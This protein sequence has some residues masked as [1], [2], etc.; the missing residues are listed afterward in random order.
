[1]N[2]QEAFDL[3]VQKSKD[4]MFPSQNPETKQC[5]YRGPNGRC[6]GVGVL[7]PDNVYRKH[8]DEGNNCSIEDLWAEI[9]DKSWVPEDMTLEDL[10]RLQSIHDN[11]ASTEGVWLH[12]RFIAS[13]RQMNYFKECKVSR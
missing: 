3:L 12:D 10:C 7:I 11:M 1:M 13:L 2:R 8:F 4:G 9:G 6:C 5:L